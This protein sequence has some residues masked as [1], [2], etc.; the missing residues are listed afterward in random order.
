MCGGML[1]LLTRLC[2]CVSVCLRV[3][4]R[5]QVQDLLQALGTLFPGCSKIMSRKGRGCPLLVPTFLS[6][7]ELETADAA[8]LLLPQ[9]GFREERN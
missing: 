1:H 9:Q 3:H 6:L 8:F 5:F 4:V 7:P 2:P